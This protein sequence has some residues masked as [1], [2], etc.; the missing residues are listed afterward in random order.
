MNL[1]GLSNLQTVTDTARVTA[2]QFDVSTTVVA[3][4]GIGAVVSVSVYV[5]R[6]ILSAREID[7]WN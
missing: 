1:Q 7:G 6:N 5:M 4:F 2:F 3:S